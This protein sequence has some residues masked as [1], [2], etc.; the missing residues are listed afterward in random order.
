KP[1]AAAAEDL[2]NC[3]RVVVLFIGLEIEAWESWHK[4]R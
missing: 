3:R 1:V 4:N 2:M